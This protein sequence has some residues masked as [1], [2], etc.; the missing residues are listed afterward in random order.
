MG[1]TGMDYMPAAIDRL[2]VPVVR[3]GSGLVDLGALNDKDQRLTGLETGSRGP[4]LYVDFDN[5]TCLDGQLP[6]ML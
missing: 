2:L 6:L 1:T 3:D 5:G 4:D